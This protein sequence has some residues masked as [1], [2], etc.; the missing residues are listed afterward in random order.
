MVHPNTFLPLRQVL[1]AAGDIT[2]SA[3]EFHQLTSY[4][5]V[6]V[7]KKKEFFNHQNQYCRY[8]A[9]V[10]S[11]CL[12]GFHTNDKGDEL[13]LFFA[14]AGQ[15]AGDKTSFYSG[16]P[17]ISGIQA[18]EKTEIVYVDK[19]D[20]ETAMDRTP[21]FE[22]WY[23]RR[24]RETLEETQR[25]FIARQTE[26]AEEKYLNLLKNEPAIVARIPQQYI[27]SYFGIKPQSLSRVRK[28]ISVD[29]DFLT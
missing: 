8:V 6:R 10:N 28:L 14:F 2:F 9:L 17:S 21:A 22:K 26:S 5:K 1:E 7:L 12:R 3:E 29:A 4:F 20:W 27:A 15:W 25:K 18:L 13:T 24:S 16:H 19:H 11:G 23:R